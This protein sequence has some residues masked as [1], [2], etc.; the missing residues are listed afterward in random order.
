V[1]PTFR[2][3]RAAAERSMHR[4]IPVAAALL[5]ATLGL[6]PFVQ[7]IELQ[8]Y[9]LRVGATA[10]PAAP[11]DR[12]SLVLIDDDSLRRMEPLVGRW[13]WPR[14]VHATVIDY[15]AAA[16]AKVIAYDILFAERDIRKFMV[17]D[18]EWTGEESDAALVDST[19]QAG[20]VVH[21][22]EASSAEL[23]DPTRAVVENFEAPALNVPAP[24]TPCVEV[25]PRVT[26]PFPALAAVSNAIGHTLFT[27]EN[28]TVRRVSPVVHAR[29]SWRGG[30]RPRTRTD[31]RPS[32]ITPSTTCSAP[33]R[34]SSKA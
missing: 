13:P 23:I 30:D 9:D 1:Q 32:R 14:L 6:L 20:N 7:T 19:R 28:G 22:A 25:R 24:P 4:L 15:L 11:S 17:G 31:S 10:R 18:T 8:T 33:S 21:V 16:G 27:L 2:G 34:K 26:P 5:A 29:R 3:R 12:I